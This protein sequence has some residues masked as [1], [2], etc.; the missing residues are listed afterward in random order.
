[1]L[2]QGAF[3]FFSSAVSAPDS[4]A[5][6]PDPEI[7]QDIVATELLDDGM[8]IST[9]SPQL[10]ISSPPRSAFS[11]APAF[12]SH[13]LPASFKVPRE[14]SS[15]RTELKDVSRSAS[16]SQYP[17][18]F[19]QKSFSAEPRFRSIND[20]LDKEKADLTEIYADAEQDE[21]D[22]DDLQREMEAFCL[23]AESEPKVGNAMEIEVFSIVTEEERAE[24]QHFTNENIS[25][26]ANSLTSALS[27]AMMQKPTEMQIVDENEEKAAAPISKASSKEQKATPKQGQ[28]RKLDDGEEQGYEKTARAGLLSQQG[29]RRFVPG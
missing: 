21:E 13:S 17:G 27:P 15:E 3:A 25:L 19:E 6:P 20:D 5:M 2:A 22:E 14:E 29:I 1:M 7:P 9:T 28:K 24:S 12:R 18:K 26:L 8:S 10:P 11:A 4:L 16:A 23:D